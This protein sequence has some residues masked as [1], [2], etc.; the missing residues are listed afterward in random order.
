VAIARGLRHPPGR[1][2]GHL[3]FFEARASSGYS[4]GDAHQFHVKSLRVYSIRFH[5][6]LDDGIG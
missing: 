2:R 3:E 4:A 1:S 5:H 6:S